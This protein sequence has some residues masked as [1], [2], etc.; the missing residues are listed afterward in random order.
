MLA[1]IRKQAVQFLQEEDGPT[2]VEY[3]I[4]L[5]FIISILSL[6]VQTLGGNANNTFNKVGTKLNNGS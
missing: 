2:A 3:G 1:L 4:L 5:A 6:V